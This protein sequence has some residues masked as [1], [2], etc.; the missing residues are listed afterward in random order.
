MEAIAKK[1]FLSKIIIPRIATF[2]ADN[3][4]F[5]ML[6]CFL[7]GTVHLS[8]AHTINF[9]RNLPRLAAFADLGWLSILW[10]M[11]LVIRWILL[12]QPLNPATLWLI[13]GGLVVVTI[14]G[15]QKGNFI[16]GFLLGLA[17]LPIKMLNSI[18]AFSDIVSYVRLFAVGLAG[19]EIAKSFNAI[20]A[21]IGFGVPLGFMA[22]LILFF[23]HA[24]NI[25]MGAMS[26]IVHGIRLNMLEF[27]GH[28]GMEWTG[29]PYKPFSDA[30]RRKD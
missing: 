28:L 4:E 29:T 10:G 15:E 3:A 12:K 2:G 16:K 20:G 6:L 19:I 14:C 24:L 11:F 1:T 13:A 9:M 17:K 18:S 8:I 22:A 21:E 27:S 25:A 7:I 23:G 30:E 5:I 26:V